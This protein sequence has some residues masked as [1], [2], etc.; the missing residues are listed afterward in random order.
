VEQQGVAIARQWQ[1]KH[2]S[3][4]MNKY[5]KIKELLKAVFSIWSA[6]RLYNPLNYWVFI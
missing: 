6:P 2:V 1:G 4:A 5:A 3:T